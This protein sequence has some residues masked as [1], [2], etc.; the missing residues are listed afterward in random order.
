MSIRAPE[1]TFM[2]RATGF[3]E[4]DLQEYFSNLVNIND[5]HQFTANRIFNVDKTAITAVQN[6]AKVVTPKKKCVSENFYRT[7]RI[8]NCSLCHCA[9]GYALEPMLIFF[10]S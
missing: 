3:N 10:Q 5:K 6:S 4:L 2:N 7:R 8:P 1:A 9:T